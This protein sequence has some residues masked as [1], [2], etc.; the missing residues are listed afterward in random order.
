[1]REKRLGRVFDASLGYELSSGDTLE[2]D[3][4]FV[5]NARWQSL[6]APLP[7]GFLPIAPDLVVE[8]LSKSTARRDRTEKWEIYAENGVDEYWIVDQ[9]R[10]EVTVFSREG[11]IFDAGRVVRKGPLSSRVLPALG[12]SVEQLFADI[13]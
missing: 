3:F 11:A 10:R 5:S 2:P 4:S 9:D 13:E 8:T 6:P 1:V 12:L 7:K